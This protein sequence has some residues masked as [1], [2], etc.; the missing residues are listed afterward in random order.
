M[1][2]LTMSRKERERMTVMAGVTDR[3][4]TLVPA[5]KLMRV[6]YRQSKR[7]WKRYQADGDAGLVHRPRGRV[8]LRR[9]APAMRA[10]VLAR[11]AEERYADFG[12]TLLAEE[13]AKRSEEHT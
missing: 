1:E 5:S 9:K 10:H 2:T 11:Y 12:P 6:S 13:L 4:L 3:K 8:G 7:I